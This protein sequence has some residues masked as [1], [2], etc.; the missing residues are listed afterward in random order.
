MGRETCSYRGHLLTYHGGDLPGFHSQVSF[1][2]RERIGVLVFVIGDHC[3]SL[4]DTISYNIYERLLGLNQT[5]WCQRLLESRLKGKKAITE[6]RARAGGDRIPDT[7]P[8]HALPDYVGEY[9][10][11]A[12]GILKIGQKDGQLQFEFHKI[13]LPLTHFH[14]DRFDTPDDELYG[15]WSVNFLTN[16]Q[17]DIDKAVMSL[18]E[19]EALFT[20]KPESLEPELLKR[21]VGTYETPTGYKFQV[22]FKE[23]NVL[24][25][26]YPVSLRKS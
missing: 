8:S 12:Y 10:H 24:Y 19:A 7:K 14:Y 11:P 18:D 26:V 23:D 5:P 20:R 17:G 22:T 16:P 25:L 15:K 21:L 13:Q 4:Y 1:M 3:S 2:P 9:E 6:V